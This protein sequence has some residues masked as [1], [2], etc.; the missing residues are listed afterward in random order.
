M[1][2]AV[3]RFPG[4]NCDHDTLWVLQGVLGWDAFPVWHRSQDLGGAQLVVLPGGFSFGDY[5][6][7][8]A[9]AARSPV[10]AAVRRHAAEGGLVLGIC[11][12][13]QVLCEAGL[14][15]GSLLPNQDLRFHC[16]P[17]LIRVETDATPFTSAAAPGRLLTLPV[18]HFQ[19]AYHVS[20]RELARLEREGR[21]V[22]RYVD[23][24]GRAVPE[25][26]FNGSVGNVAGV[27][28][29]NRRVLGM[30]PHPE[31]ASEPLLGGTDGL[32]I[33]RS[34]EQALSVDGWL[35]SGRI[36]S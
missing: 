27:C 35:A 20:A 2:A 33:W 11:N 24:L 13:F 5:L 10:M 17:T 31:R 18:A 3:I 28:S 8:G 26:N 19:G 22:F 36:S 32:A 6:R 12:G 29:A 21:I 34:V 30:M 23:R 14:L 4:S 9:I 16:H 7:A 25:A 15:P 1:K